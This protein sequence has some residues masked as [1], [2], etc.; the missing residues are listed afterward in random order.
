MF[1][2]LEIFR[3]NSKLTPE[4]IDSLCKK[5]AE[6][7]YVDC[8]GPNRLVLVKFPTSSP[9][10]VQLTS[11]FPNAEIKPFSDIPVIVVTL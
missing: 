4:E 2:Y 8:T 11:A 9:S 10:V 5:I 3:N 1:C 6:D 7:S